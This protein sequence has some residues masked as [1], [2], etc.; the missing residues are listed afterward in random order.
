MDPYTPAEDR[1]K[2]EDHRAFERAVAALNRLIERVRKY[3]PE[4]NYYLANDTLN[5]M[6]GPSHEGASDHPHHER[7]ATSQLLHRSGG[8]DW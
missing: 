4:A 6:V 5:L 8:G 7:V 3:E 2:P 1:I